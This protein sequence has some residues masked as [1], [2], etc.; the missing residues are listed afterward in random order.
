[1]LE[2]FPPLSLGTD[3]MQCRFIFAGDGFLFPFL[4]FL[5]IL[6]VLPCNICEDTF[7]SLLFYSRKLQ[8][9]LPHGFLQPGALQ[10]LFL[11]WH[12]VYLRAPRWGFHCV[13]AARPS[14]SIFF[15]TFPLSP[16]SQFSKGPVYLD[17][18]NKRL[19]SP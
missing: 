8:P 1:M 10:G 2:E 6:S 12:S 15:I 19:F 14:T 3:G 17:A 16:T 5:G 7:G 4:C 11:C 13:G 18:G 9:F